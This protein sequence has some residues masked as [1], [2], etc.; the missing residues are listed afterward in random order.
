MCSA[1]V[2]A[3]EAAKI[4]SSQDSPKVLPTRMSAIRQTGMSALR[5]KA[6]GS[7]QS[8][9]FGKAAE[10]VHA[11]DGL[12]A[13]AFDDVVLGAHHDQPAGAMVQPPGD[14]YDVCSYNMLGVR[15][16]LAVKQ[17]NKWFVAVSGLITR[18]NFFV[19]FGGFLRGRE[20]S[21]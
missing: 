8:R 4:R 14:F 11:L 9:R 3:C 19:Q 21:F 13:C 6:V 20:M 16:C 2:R 5:W 15:Q 12:A 1:G 10:D 18:G 7:H 17:A